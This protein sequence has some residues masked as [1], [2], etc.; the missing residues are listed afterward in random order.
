M[1]IVLFLTFSVCLKIFQMLKMKAVHFPL[2]VSICSLGRCVGTPAA[3]PAW[4]SAPPVR[5]AEGGEHSHRKGQAPSAL[6]L[7]WPH[8]LILEATEP[9]PQ[10]PGNML[11]WE[12][13]L[14]RSQE[15]TSYSQLPKDVE[16][17]AVLFPFYRWF[18]DSPDAGNY[19][20][21]HKAVFL[22]CFGL[23]RAQGNM[24]G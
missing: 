21:G 22:T 23:C 12:A 11:M 1:F 16:K 8:V 7:L 18:S 4:C 10:Q 20:A 17:A 2:R 15:N 19:A 3:G 9:Q 24:N 5:G 14:T 6:P 13:L